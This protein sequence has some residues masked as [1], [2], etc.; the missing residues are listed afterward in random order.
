[1]AIAAL[2]LGTH[3]ALA[4]HEGHG[5]PPG[6][7]VQSVTR[8]VASLATLLKQ[9]DG[10]LRAIERAVEETNPRLVGASLEDFLQAMDGIEAYFDAAS[11]D[12]G[13]TLKDATKTQR[14]L[15]RHAARLGDLSRR[16]TAELRDGLSAALDAC[17]RAADAT[18]A[19]GAR[20]PHRRSPRTQATTAASAAAVAG[21]TE[22]GGTTLR[23]VLP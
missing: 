22:H 2:L 14:A 5:A 9:S 6:K 1:M 19:A 13:R 12:P 18:A 11:G 15:E 21:I 20:K 4:Q 23:L 16:A 7:G 17:D 3:T 8:D 10:S